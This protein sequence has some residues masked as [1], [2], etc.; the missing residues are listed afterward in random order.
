VV[1]PRAVLVGLTDRQINTGLGF[2]SNVLV[3]D[4]R[5][6]TSVPSGGWTFGQLEAAVSRKIWSLH[7]RSKKIGLLESGP[8]SFFFALLSF[9]K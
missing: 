4:C 8:T 7:P 9:S 6:Y 1:D 3:L 5:H 2:S